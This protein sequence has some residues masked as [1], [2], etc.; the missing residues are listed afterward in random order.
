MWHVNPTDSRLKSIMKSNSSPFVIVGFVAWSFRSRDVAIG[1]KFVWHQLNLFCSIFCKCNWQGVWSAE[2]TVSGFQ[3][4]PKRELVKFFTSSMS[5]ITTLPS[6]QLTRCLSQVVSTYR[7][8]CSERVRC[9]NLSDQGNTFRFMLHPGA[10]LE[11]FVLWKE[12]RLPWTVSHYVLQ[13]QIK[14]QTS[15]WEYI[16]LPHSVHWSLAKKVRINF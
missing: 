8:G 16:Y 3:E 11:A 12:S 10:L 7:D 2:L 13:R 1:L 15:Y 9:L 4:L 5:D 14:L 6:G